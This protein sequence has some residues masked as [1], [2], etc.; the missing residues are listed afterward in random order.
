MAGASAGAARDDLAR[1]PLPGKRAS[2]SRHTG[3]ENPGGG[4]GSGGRGAAPRGVWGR[5]GVGRRRLL[6][7]PPDAGALLINCAVP[8]ARGC[9]P[10]SRLPV[11]GARAAGSWGPAVAEGVGV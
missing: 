3:S 6:P 9:E 5:W 10:E 8:S 1:P 7:R 11:G 4:G 2:P